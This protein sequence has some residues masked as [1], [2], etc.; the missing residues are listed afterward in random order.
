M[1]GGMK[2]LLV[3]GLHRTTLTDQR[4]PDFRAQGAPDQFS[5]GDPNT[6]QRA[7]LDDVSHSAFT[8]A[9]SAKFP[10]SF[11]RCI[12]DRPR[13]VG[14]HDLLEYQLKQIDW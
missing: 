12:H 1:K 4:C 13:I 8:V 10:P 6:P 5:Y 11:T 7:T 3:I 14:I 9:P 2:S